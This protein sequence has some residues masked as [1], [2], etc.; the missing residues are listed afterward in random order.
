MAV[1][2]PLVELSFAISVGSDEKLVVGDVRVF[3]SYRRQLSSSK[4]VVPAIGYPESIATH[5]IV[6]VLCDLPE[7][8]VSSSSACIYR[9]WLS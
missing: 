2:L 1:L 3:G 5:P 6:S 7:P 4:F 8:I 9:S